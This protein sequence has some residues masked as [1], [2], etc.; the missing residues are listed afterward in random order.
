MP[1]KQG[2]L[3]KVVAN[4]RKNNNNGCGDRKFFQCKP[5]FKMTL[6]HGVLSRVERCLSV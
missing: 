2:C 4:H 6:R 3:K 5:C 1:A